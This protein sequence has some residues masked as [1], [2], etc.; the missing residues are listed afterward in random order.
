MTAL[1]R[2]QPLLT[3]AHITA[4]VTGAISLA[5]TLGA[6]PATS[7]KAL[8]TAADATIAAVFLV[9]SVVPVYAHAFSARKSVTPVDDPRARDGSRLVP[10]HSA[11]AEPSV[12]DAL[13]AAAA[14]YPLAA[15]SAAGTPPAASRDPY[16][17]PS[18]FSIP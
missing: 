18:P 16:A 1:K 14:L 2:P 12:V 8:M 10:E 6:L 5:V 17:S 4:A 13:A 3:R 15:P 11:A 9:L 7:G